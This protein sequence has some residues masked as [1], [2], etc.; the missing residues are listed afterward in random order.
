MSV[1]D[2]KAVVARWFSDFWGSDFDL[3]TVSPF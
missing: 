2:N 1:E 3:T